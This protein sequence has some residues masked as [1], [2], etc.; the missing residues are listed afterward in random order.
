[1]MDKTI[2]SSVI[3]ATCDVEMYVRAAISYVVSKNIG[4]QQIDYLNRRHY[5][6]GK[7]NKT[8]KDIKLIS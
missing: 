7:K 3:D 1:M 8:D 4:E 2:T 5:Q 6:S